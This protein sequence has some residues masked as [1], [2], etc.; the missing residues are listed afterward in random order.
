M[1]TTTCGECE[2]SLV[3]ESTMP[4]RVPADMFPDATDDIVE[5]HMPWMVPHYMDAETRMMLFSF[6]SFVIRTGR[7]TILVDACVGNHKERPGR[8]NWHRQNWPYMANLAA[9]GVQPEEI[10][11]VMCTH[12][13]IDHVGWNTQLK[14]GRW[15]PTFPNAR[16]VFAQAEVDHW[17]TML[18]ASEV[19]DNVFNDSVLPILE[20]GQADLVAMD[21]EIDH[22]IV[23]EPTPGHT[24]GHVALKLDSGG[25]RALFIGDL[26]HHPLQVREPQLS[27]MVCTDAE[28]SRTSRYD[29]LNKYADSD[30]LICPAHFT[31][32]EV[33]H[34][35]SD[36]DGWRFDFV[37]D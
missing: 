7:L 18:G 35:K 14:D 6:K 34:V 10:D 29:F 37:A 31:G 33:G 15:V 1:K 30:A 12:L 20:A 22:G 27:S 21:H 16:Y 25:D 36:G 23:L 26:F 2:I 24:P 11:I 28:L 32:T 9:V 13:H 19:G 8:P 4:F 5:K 3:E 17:Q